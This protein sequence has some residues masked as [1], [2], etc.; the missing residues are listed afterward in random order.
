MWLATLNWH[1]GH[2]NGAT[3]KHRTEGKHQCD[4]GLYLSAHSGHLMGHVFWAGR[5]L[6]SG[7]V[8]C[9]GELS[10]PR[11]IISPVLALFPL[12]PLFLFWPFVFFFNY[13]FVLLYPY[14]QF[15]LLSLNLAAS[16]SLSVP[17]SAPIRPNSA[18]FTKMGFNV[19]QFIKC[20]IQGYGHTTVLVEN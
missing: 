20:S 3:R 10:G 13:F 16:I 14:H 7:A 9:V 11:V 6:L 1:C 18:N 8:L 17:V 12:F 4:S 15:L 19:I 2:K 5:I